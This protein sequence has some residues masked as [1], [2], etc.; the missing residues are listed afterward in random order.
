VVDAAMV[1]GVALLS[2]AIHGIAAAGG[3]SPEP[4]TNVLD[5]GAHFYEVYETADGGHVAVGAVEPQ[6]YAALLELLDIDDAPQWER[7]RWPELKARLAAAFGAHTRAEWASRLQDTDA[8]ATVV[9]GL[10]EAPSHPHNVA[11]DTFIERDGVV[12][13]A[14]APRFS[15]TPGSAD[16]PLA[17]PAD[18]LKRWGLGAG[19][20]KV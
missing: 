18:T 10:H 17:E 20:L 2:A 13:P 6:F 19:T 8:C 12:Q 7:Q 16:R 15:R 1:D 14:A 9:L 5:S 3:W 4:G 11:R